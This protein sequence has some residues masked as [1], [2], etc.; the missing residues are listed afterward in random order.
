[1]N[2]RFL[3]RLLQFAHSTTNY[4]AGCAAG[5]ENEIRYPNFIGEIAGTKRASILICQLKRR[6]RSKCRDVAG[7]KSLDLAA[8]YKKSNGGDHQRDPEQNRFPG[9][10]PAWRSG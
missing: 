4:R 7:G 1:M 9:E 6:N 10:S 5:R 8:P 2:I 3:E